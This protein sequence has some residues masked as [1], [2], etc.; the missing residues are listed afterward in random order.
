MDIQ[1]INV[2]FLKA[3]RFLTKE[4]VKKEKV[5]IRNDIK[6]NFIAGIGAVDHPE[7]GVFV[8][9]KGELKQETDSEDSGFE[10]VEDDDED[11]E[12][13]EDTKK[14]GSGNNKSNENK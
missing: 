10:D 12:S 3:K 14:Q 4:S 6:S 1:E 5:K 13:E 11:Y 9:A 7:K 2:L 8:N